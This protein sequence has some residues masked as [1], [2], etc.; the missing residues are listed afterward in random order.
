M[1]RLRVGRKKHNYTNPDKP[2][3]ASLNTILERRKFDG[4][5]KVITYNIKLS[6][7]INKATQL[8]AEHDDLKICFLKRLEDRFTV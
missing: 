2:R 8:L 7:K 1:K 3:Y 4:I 5:I 6:R